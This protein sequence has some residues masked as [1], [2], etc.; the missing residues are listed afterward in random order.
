[1][2]N[3]ATGIEKIKNPTVLINGLKMDLLIFK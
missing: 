2:N 3:A 1:V